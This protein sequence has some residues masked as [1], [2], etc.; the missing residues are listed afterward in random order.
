MTPA[1]ATIRP[2]IHQVAAERGVTYDEIVRPC[3]RAIV[4]CARREVW[5]RI[6][7][8]GGYTIIGISKAWGCSAKAVADGIHATGTALDAIAPIVDRVSRQYGS[9]PEEI[10]RPDRRAMVCRAR[11]AV[12]AACNDAG[13]SSAEIGRYFN[14]DHTTVLHG[15]QRHK[16][17]STA[18][19][20]PVGY[21]VLS[22][23]PDQRT[24]AILAA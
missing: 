8:K 19:K 9:T 12:F 13:F 15:I 23:S 1:Q 11:F 24:G 20:L 14:R 7:A 21:T 10:V 22:Q 5:R 6:H 18:K 2:I 3:R 16:E 4:V 17:L